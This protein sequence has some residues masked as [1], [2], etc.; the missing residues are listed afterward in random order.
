MAH[1]ALRDT[2]VSLEMRRAQGAR[3]SPLAARIF[4]RT[5]RLDANP[6]GITTLRIDAQND[7]VTL[8]LQAPRGDDVIACGYGDWRE[9]RIVASVDRPA[10][11]SGTYAWSDDNTLALILCLSETPFVRTHT[12]RI[13]NN[14]DALEFETHMNVGFLPQSPVIVIG[15]AID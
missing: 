11:S 12:L 9:S 13:G 5:Y 4:G 15:Q 14:G 10:L 6:D 7:G 8:T 3:H 2:L 1:N